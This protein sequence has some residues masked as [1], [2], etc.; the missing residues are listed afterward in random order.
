MFVA[1]KPFVV[2]LLGLIGFKA[3]IGLVGFGFTKP[4][5]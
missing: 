2:L 3:C 4:K 5:P 1:Y